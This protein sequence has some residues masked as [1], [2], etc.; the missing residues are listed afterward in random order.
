M[1]QTIEDPTLYAPYYS[2]DLSI[3]IV[4]IEAKNKHHAEAIMQKFIDEIAVVMD[5]QVRWHEADWEIAENVYDPAT[6]TWS[7]Q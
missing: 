3:S 5:E 4:N 2:C 1:T 6:G 7:E